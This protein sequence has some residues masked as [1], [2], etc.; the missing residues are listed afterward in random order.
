MKPLNV[1]SCR[2]ITFIYKSIIFILLFTL[3]KGNIIPN[4]N[5]IAFQNVFPSQY[6]SSAIIEEEEAAAAAASAASGS[7]AGT[8]VPN[9]NNVYSPNTLTAEQ[10]EMLSKNNNMYANMYTNNNNYNNVNKIITSR[11]AN[12]YATSTT[13]SSSSSAAAAAA[14]TSGNPIYFSQL[15]LKTRDPTIL[16]L[17]QAQPRFN[18]IAQIIQVDPQMLNEIRSKGPYT[19]FAPTDEALGRMPNGA[20]EWLI[21]NPPLLRRFVQTHIVRGIIIFAEDL[22]DEDRFISVDGTVHY[23]TQDA[24]GNLEID[25]AARFYEAKKD[26]VS[27]NGIVHGIGNVLIPQ[28]M[29]WPAGLPKCKANCLELKRPLRV[30]PFCIKRCV[31]GRK[32]Y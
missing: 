17:F 25:E 16:E 18:K 23:I 15:P 14:G 27:S 31:E 9:F 10:I 5:N 6:Y 7:A 8:S 2:H 1:S 30:V 11:Q 4:T 24:K 28:G 22:K 21:A 19:V 3:S 12:P 26:E 29:I 32:E 20:L 13:S